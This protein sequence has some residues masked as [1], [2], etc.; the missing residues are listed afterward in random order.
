MNQEL[1]TEI[2]TDIHEARKNWGYDIELGMQT[3]CTVHSPVLGR[4]PL[5]S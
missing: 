1:Q 2:L 5:L 3:N 4:Q